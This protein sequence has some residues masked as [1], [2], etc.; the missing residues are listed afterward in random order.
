MAVGA[1]TGAD[2]E[3]EG[4]DGGDGVGDVFGSEA[5]GEK[6]RD[7]DALADSATDGPVVGAAGAPEL[8]DGEFLIAGVEED[9]VDVWSDGGSLFDGFGT[10]DMDDLD[11]FDSGESGFEVAVRAVGEV[12]D[13]LNCVGA[14]DAML[15]DDFVDG[16]AAGEKEGADGR[17]DGCGDFGDEF[18]RDDS[19]AAWHVGNEA[20]RGSSGGDGEGGF[21]FAAHAAD[22]DARGGSFLHSFISPRR[23]GGTEEIRETN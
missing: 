21:F 12:I 8:L 16:L 3:G 13:D 23:H 1:D 10:G 17:R 22:F 6:E 7:R 5:S 9:G 2:V 20:E 14:A 4:T 15:G 19:G 18:I 11:D